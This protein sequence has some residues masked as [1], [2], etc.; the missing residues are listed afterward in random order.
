MMDRQQLRLALD[1]IDQEG[2]GENVDND[3]I[4]ERAA[5]EY[6][7]LLEQSEQIWWCELVE[8]S[9]RRE[10]L[11]C[12]VNQGKDRHDAEYH[13]GCGWRLLTPTE[14]VGA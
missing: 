9:V 8:C 5:L 13:T 6:A 11:L 14:E 12:R 1:C 7:D 4:V 10:G 3:V 2:F